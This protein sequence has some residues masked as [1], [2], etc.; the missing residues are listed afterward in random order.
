MTTTQKPNGHTTEHDQNP[1]TPCCLFATAAHPTQVYPPSASAASRTPSSASR[2]RP[3]PS[4]SARRLSAAIPPEG[5]LRPSS[6]PARLRARRLDVA[7]QAV[8]R[9]SQACPPEGGGRSAVSAYSVGPYWVIKQTCKVDPGL[10]TVSGS[11]RSFP[12]SWLSLFPSTSSEPCIS[13]ST[14]SS[15]PNWTSW[16]GSLRC[17]GEEGPGM[18]MLTGTS[19]TSRK[20]FAVKLRAEDTEH[21]ELQGDHAE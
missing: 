21:R 13:M 12:T 6:P 11:S 7:R 5:H 9:G 20:K 2:S 18:F 17:G 19:M 1:T 14:S 16:G 3:C 4:S 10:R 15:D 8:L